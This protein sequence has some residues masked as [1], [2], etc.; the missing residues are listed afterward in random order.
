MRGRGSSSAGSATSREDRRSSRERARR[1]IRLRRCRYPA[2]EVDLAVKGGRM[3]LLTARSTRSATEVAKFLGFRLDGRG[4]LRHYSRCTPLP[5][6][7]GQRPLEVPW[8][9]CGG[10]RAGSRSRGALLSFW[11]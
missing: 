11:A 9:E 4:A 5:A 1:K 7:E 10:D 8:E 6:L 3:R 2:P